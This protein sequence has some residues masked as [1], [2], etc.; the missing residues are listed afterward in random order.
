MIWFILGAI[1]C[2]AVIIYVFYEKFFLYEKIMVVIVAPIVSFIICC[3][4]LLVVSLFASSSSNIE[5][6]NM[7]SD[8]KIIALK[9]NHGISSRF[10]LTSAYVNED[11]YYHYAVETEFGYNTMKAKASDSYIRYTDGDA[12]IETYKPKFTNSI[13]YWFA[14][15]ITGNRYIIYCPENTIVT[16]FNIDLE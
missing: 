6:N 13:F 7:D 2:I 11:L 3:V 8:M 14:M 16:E 1:V 5:Y 12:H 9:D 4:V 15:P 10:Y